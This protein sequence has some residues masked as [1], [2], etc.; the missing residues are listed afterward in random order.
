M[1]FLGPWMTENTSQAMEIFFSPQVQSV[2]SDYKGL[3]LSSSILLPLQPW[4]HI[5]LEN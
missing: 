3:W 1:P 2:P 4:W 5:M